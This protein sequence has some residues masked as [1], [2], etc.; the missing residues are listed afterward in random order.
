MTGASG[1]EIRHILCGVDGSDQSC[2]AAEQAA[3]LAIA[4]KANLT[5]LAVAREVQADTE[6]DA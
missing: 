3:W 4:L 1:P 6:I 2:R 5:Y